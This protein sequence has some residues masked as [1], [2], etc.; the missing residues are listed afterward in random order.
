MNQPAAPI[1]SSAYEDDDEI[2]LA[3]YLDFL[4]DY[5]WLIAGVALVVMSLG[6]AYALLAKPIYQAN[7]LIQVEDSANSSKNMLGDLSS[8]FDVK[9]AATAEMEILR[10]RMVVSHAVDNLQLHNNI[11]P[12]YMPVIGAWM[13]SRN[14]KLSTPGLFGYGGYVWG[15]EK[16]DVALF[17]V[18]DSLLNHDFILT[19]EGDDE[20]LL[21]QKEQDI[22][23]KGRVGTALHV[24]TEDG[25]LDLHVARIKATPGAQFILTGTSR[26]ATIERLQGAMG[27]AEKG[28]QSGVISV[29]LEGTNPKLTR[30]TLNEIG[31]EYVRQNVERKSEEAEKSLA[32]LDKQLPQLKQ[33][34]E[35]SE[36][37]YNQFRNSRGTIDLT[38]ESRLLLQQSITVQT[39]LIELKQKREE[40]LIRFGTS[41]PAIV[42]VESLMKELSNE[43]K[44]I[45]NKIKQLPALQQDAVRLTREVTLNTELYTALSNSAQQL[46]LVKAGKVGNARL[47]DPAILP[48]KPVQPK[49]MIVA[50]LSVAI[51]LFL[52]VVC[53]FIRK[54]LYGGIE[55]AHEIEDGLGVTVFA[56]IPHS[57]QQE[58]LYSQLAAKST[59]ISVLA[60]NAPTDPIVESLR[61]FYTGLQFSML[62][63]Q[64]NIVLITGA[65]PGI[66]KSFV[67]VN[68]AA[69]VAMT[70]K[71]V[72]LVDAD[73]R[74][75]Y[76]H[77]YFGLS[78]N[79]GLTDYIAGTTALEQAI[80]RDVVKNV[81]FIATGNLPPNPAE[82]LMHESFSELLR[83]LSATYDL[84]L[85]DS[86]PVLAVADTLIMGPQMGGVFL[87]ARAG[88]STTG[89]LQESMKRL[90]Q[91]GIDT[92]G[93]VFND[94]KL[95][96][97]RYGYGARYGKYRQVEYS[98]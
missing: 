1:A 39:K 5:R 68:F 37:Q 3:S 78:R 28:K 65:T 50:A 63:A 93:V 81:D 51:G 92:K 47:L 61:S 75:G 29:T 59:Q 88:V 15:A 79:N 17:K 14:K 49:R 18:P 2:N 34:L 85:I 19:V 95:R 24:P 6:A 53:A 66:G 41:H 64:N 21:V 20:F 13:A 58:E 32:F 71:R 82:L 83:S 73:L 40:L 11:R 7:M 25:G 62:G 10:S 74:K 56:S 26:T 27:I 35:Q 42:G 31:R 89:E 70:G 84:V 87:V 67:S 57:K 98:Y 48:E 43:L 52:G 33:Q 45:S 86:P 60:A 4:I 72:L 77:Q 80:H 16:I 30:D 55:D 90:N 36:V 12:M 44:I 8:M 69:V 97:G 9:A 94:V 22:E 54:S 76:L 96:N 91:A 23:L 38:E 46:R